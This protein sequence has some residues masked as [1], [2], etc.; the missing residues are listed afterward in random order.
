VAQLV[1]VCCCCQQQTYVVC[2]GRGFWQVVRTYVLWYVEKI[3]RKLAIPDT[4]NVSGTNLWRLVGGLLA[5]CADFWLSGRH[6]ADLLATF[7]AKI[8]ID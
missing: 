5:K 2:R 4:K 7:P 1:V 3:W 6:V 8:M